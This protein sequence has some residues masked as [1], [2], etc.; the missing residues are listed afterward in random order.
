MAAYEAFLA[1]LREATDQPVELGREGTLQ[2]A[3]DDEG[4]RD[5]SEL[6]RLLAES[7]VEHRRMDGAAARAL[8]PGLSHRVIAALEIPAHGYVSP[9]GLVA[10]LVDGA[11]RLGAVF[12]LAR[13]TGL[14]AGDTT[15]VETQ[16]GTMDADAVV[17]ASGSWLSDL[18][19]SADSPHQPPS[20][21][22]TNLH[23]PAAIRP[24]RGQLLHLSSCTPA[25]SRV[26][27]GPGCYIVPR[28]DGTVLVGATV[29]DVG[30]DERATLGGVRS[31]ADAASALVPGLDS[32]VFKEVRVGLRPAT[33]DELPI[34]GPS[35]TMRQVF[36]AA[37]HYRNGVLLAPLTAGLVAD[38]VLD[39]R[40]APE[41]AATRPARF[42]L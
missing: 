25:A 20:T 14:S 35:A 12:S 23:R 27:W 32:A 19:S 39:G 37:G 8:E 16:V 13:V 33:S 22:H 15:C 5:L 42:G 38:L 18:P 30:F 36:Y 17:L 7:D 2:C 6:A 1:S 10:A 4:A 9:D 31:L 40:A 21:V 24:I 26:L 41:L 28:R 11:T 29:E 34:I 3:F